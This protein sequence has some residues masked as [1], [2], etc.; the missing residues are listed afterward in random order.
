MLA[1]HEKYVVN[2]KGQKKA[3]V[4]PY[5]EREKILEILEEYD[6]IRAYDQ[7]KAEKSDPIPFKQVLKKIN[8]HFED[9]LI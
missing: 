9:L 6:D 8:A 3:V 4:L 7:V 5:N 2:Q 1:L